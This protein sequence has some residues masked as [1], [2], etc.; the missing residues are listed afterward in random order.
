MNIK[1]I[2]LDSE[3]KEEF[4]ACALY[5]LKILG[6]DREKSPLELVTAVNS[7]IDYWQAN[8]GQNNIDEITNIS[9]GLGIVWGDAVCREFD[10][11]W[12]R[13]EQEENSWYVIS[14]PDR[15]YVCYP[16]YDVNSLLKNS[17]GDNCALL[18]FNGIKD[19][20]LPEATE[21]SFTSLGFGG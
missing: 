8:D 6:L 19:N 15:K 11:E 2:G 18:V 13:I 9:L 14:S 4:K 1:E 21:N 5:G 7:Y 12:T 3:I 10:W 17:E 16:T 20:A